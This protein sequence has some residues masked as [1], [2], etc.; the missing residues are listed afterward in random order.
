MEIFTENLFFGPRI[1][2]FI[3]FILGK[4]SRGPEAVEQSLFKGLVEL[5]VPFLVNQKLKTGGSVCVL[6]G[7]KTL[8]WAIEQK[9]QGIIKK[10]IAGPNLVVSPKDS[11]A[12]LTDPLIDI[13]IVPSIWV[14]EFYTKIAPETGEKIK[15]WPAGVEKIAIF[16]EKKEFDFLIYNKI[17]DQEFLNNIVGALKERNLSYKLLNYGEFKRQDYFAYLSKSKAEVYLSKSESQGL[18]MFEAWARN[19]PTL[20]WE[21][22]EY[23]FADGKILGKISAPYLTPECGMAFDSA[24]NFKAKLNQFLNAK[25]YPKEYLDQ[26]FTNQLCAK[27]YLEIIKS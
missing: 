7:V 26:N 16:E 11:G 1:K 13:I 14:K 23:N 6:S 19:V 24:N 5:K 3:K 27:K 18:A 4:H 17:Q 25:F 2:N 21:S 9:R 8:L 10:I 20:V 15:V 22:G 12:I